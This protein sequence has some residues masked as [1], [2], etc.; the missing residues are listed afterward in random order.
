[1]FF[2]GEKLKISIVIFRLFF[3]PFFTK[4]AEKQF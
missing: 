2:R 4:L 3:T 1:M